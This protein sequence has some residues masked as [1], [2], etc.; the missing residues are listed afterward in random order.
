M[1]LIGVVPGIKS[2]SKIVN[3]KS[4]SGVYIHIPF[5]RQ[6]C[7]YCNFHYSTSMQLKDELIAALVKE[8]H[9]SPG[10]TS[11]ASAPDGK[12]ICETIYFGGGTPSILEP[13][14]LSL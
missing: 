6:A 9:L 12:E 2:K 3:Q 13:G 4:L 1:D 14:D 8:I 5:C 7:H 10:Y 11:P